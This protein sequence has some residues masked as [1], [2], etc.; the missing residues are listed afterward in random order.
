MAKKRLTK[1]QKEQAQR[2]ALRQRVDDIY[3]GAT[4]DCW[5][6]DNGE[7]WPEQ[8]M[9]FVM[10]LRTAFQIPMNE[11]E[12]EPG[13]EHLWS[14]WNLDKMRTPEAATEFLFEHHV[15]A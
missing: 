13:N 6:E 8:F 2:D 10:A 4:G 11:E 1:E 3:L 9:S 7:P 12:G 5:Q 14:L 15:T